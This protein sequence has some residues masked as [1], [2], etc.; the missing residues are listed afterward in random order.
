[1]EIYSLDGAHHAA[2]HSPCV[3]YFW[4]LLR[5][6]L[7]PSLM[8]NS[9]DQQLL[10]PAQPARKRVKMVVGGAVGTSSRCI[11]VVVGHLALSIT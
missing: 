8:F 11:E 6:F 7:P 3:R 4:D 1:M 10:D 2:Q 9:R 5:G